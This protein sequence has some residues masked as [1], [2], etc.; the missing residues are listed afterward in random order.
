MFE[1]AL[2]ALQEFAKAIVTKLFVTASAD[3]LKTSLAAIRA[4]NARNRTVL[5]L[6]E[7]LQPFFRTELGEADTLILTNALQ[8]RFRQVA[9][10]PQLLATHRFNLD[11][12]SAEILAQAPI[13]ECAKSPQLARLLD[14]MTRQ[15]L[16]VAIAV[17][18]LIPEWE[19]ISWAENFRAFDELHAKLEKQS[20]LLTRMIE[21]PSNKITSFED[22]YL[23]YVAAEFQRVYVKGLGNVGD[24]KA[25]SL[26]SLFINLGLRRA[27]TE[28]DLKLPRPSAHT[29]PES[30]PNRPAKP[31]VET[32]DLHSAIAGA[33]KL[34]VLGAPGT[35]KSTLAQ[36]LALR[37]A[38]KEEIIPSNGHQPIVPFLLRVRSFINFDQL[39]SPKD[40]VAICAPLLD[41]SDSSA[42]VTAV[43]RQGRALILVDGLDEC[44]IDSG[45]ALGTVGQS[46]SEREKVIAWIEG[47]LTRIPR[48]SHSCDIEAGR[49]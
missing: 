27:A 17:S 30:Q 34:V 6:L 47:C 45:T 46:R 38:L 1:L 18:D 24:V 3:K 12:L 7:S 49:L 29:A 36:F 25:L 10:T 2:P 39:P 41:S 21:E 15:T 9:L 42:F 4:E 32:V 8:A 40:L 23:R 37:A 35:G 14:D 16:L 33:S 44:E 22:E 43:L 28:S 31:Q 13:D 5:R 20:G 48:Q 19:R 26:D 11:S